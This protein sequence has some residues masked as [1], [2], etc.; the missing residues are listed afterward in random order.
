M[1]PCVLIVEDDDTQLEYLKKLVEH[2]GYDSL[3]AGDGDQALKILK[4]QGH[5]VDVVILDLILPGKD[6]LSVIAEMK[7]M[8]HKAP[9]LALTRI[10]A[11][12][13]VDQIMK[14]GVYD[15]IVKPAS[16][17]RLK[18]SINNA[19][20]HAFALKKLSFI[21]SEQNNT[22]TLDMLTAHSSTMAA[23]VENAKKAA[24]TIAPILITGAEGTGKTI[25][26]KAIHGSSKRVSS[27][28]ITV[29][30][31]AFEENEIVDSLFGKCITSDKISTQALE[32]PAIKQA[33]NGTLYIKN[34]D[35]LS[36]KGQALL[37]NMLQTNEI[38]DPQ[39]QKNAKVNIRL[40]SS[41]S[42][43]LIQEIHKGNFREDLYYR[44]CVYPIEMPVLAKRIEDISDLATDIIAS[45]A[46]EFERPARRLS[47]DVI[48]TLARTDWTWNIKSLK[49]LLKR[50]VMI[51]DSHEVTNMHIEMAS[52]L[53]SQ[54]VFQGLSHKIDRSKQGSTYAGKTNE[55]VFN[56]PPLREENPNSPF[57]G[58]A[59]ESPKN[60]ANVTKL[61]VSFQEKQ[62]ISILNSKGSIRSFEE[63]ENDILSIALEHHRGNL[64][65]VAKELGLGRST[66]YRKLEKVNKCA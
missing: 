22:L 32:K 9:V 63:I 65:R 25:L 58:K 37:I 21:K 60:N 12:D 41:S 27:P 23:T 59:I 57:I 33:H 14:S 55:K 6:G 48:K 54:E 4:E 10:G 18:I 45:Y 64:S 49:Q 38:Y 42:K 3:T 1:S 39:L 20:N 36:L 53:F 16:L 24:V 47:M 5:N 7:T 15:F 56:H 43:D 46:A 17:E 28:Y 52:N 40:I 29:D 30:C 62:Q 44:L 19:I 51:C 26:S 66:L 34:I 31:A 8:G 61:P 50:V 35:A 13:I 2:I 11:M